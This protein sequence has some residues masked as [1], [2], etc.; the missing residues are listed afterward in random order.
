[1]KML[2]KALCVAL[3]LLLMPLPA[4]AAKDKDAKKPAAPPKAPVVVTDTMISARSEIWQDLNAGAIG[5]A[6]V[7]IMDNGKIVYSEGFGMADRASAIPVDKDTLFNIGSVSK[8]YTAVAIML[9]VDAG[10][11]DLDKPVAAYLPDFVMADDRYKNITVRMTLNH[12][13]GLPGTTGENNFG[14]AFNEDVYKDTLAALAR[15]QLKHRPGEMAIYSNDGFTLAEMIVVRVSGQPFIDFLSDRLF[16]PLGLQHTGHSVGQWPAA[17]GLTAAKFYPPGRTISEPLEIVSLVGAGGMAASAEDLCRFADLFSGKTAPILSPQA[18][19]ELRR[20]QPSA[21]AGRLRSPDISWGLGWDVTDLPLYKGQNIKILG[22]GGNSGTYTAQLLTAP[23]QRI[24]VAIVS[25]GRA[26]SAPRIADKVLT[27][28]LAGK[29]LMKQPAADQPDMPV[30][31]QPIPAELKS[32]EGYYSDGKGVVRLSLDLAQ[33]TLTTYRTEGGVETPVL[34]AVYYDGYF[35]RNGSLKGPKFYLSAQADK[36]YFVIHVASF[37][38]DGIDTEKIEPVAA[39]AQLVAPIDGQRWLRR[40]VKPYEGSMSLA[41][42]MTVSRLVTALPG[43][44]GFDGIKKVQ[45]PL[46]AS[47]AVGSKRDLTELRL[48]AK[49][50]RMWAWSGG[51]LFMP[52]DLAPTLTAGTANVRIEADGYNQWLKVGDDSLLTFASPAG[53]RVVL[54]GPDGRP[55]Y[56]NVMDKGAVFA[57]SGSYLE[58]AGKPGDV[59]TVTAKGVG[60]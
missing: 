51:S 16:R 48:V 12:T 13:S 24:S 6:A 4:S 45:S 35:Y 26:G 52:A 3:C 20:V 7:A 41:D 18:L 59:F 2:M 27:A 57:P 9:L 31:G 28:Y 30:K 42:H 56:D 15:S 47:M 22:K 37:G 33:G 40:N 1:M 29:G 36:R 58:L 54:L 46:F 50:G 5:S 53:G 8:V 34:S 17:P 44:I 49:G 19:E 10:K 43:Y 23:D 55:L 25:T 60:E 21:T 11:V 39:P 38:G 14:F 32:F